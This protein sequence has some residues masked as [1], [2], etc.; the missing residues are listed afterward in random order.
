MRATSSETSSER[1]S[2]SR[3]DL[4]LA[5]WLGLAVGLIA[6]AFAGTSTGETEVGDRDLLF[7][8]SFAVQSLIGYAFLTA[9]TLAIAKLFPSVWSALGFRSF[10]LRWLWI[11]LGLT[12]AALIVSAALEPLVHAGE[13]QGLAP[14]EWDG[15][16]AGAFVVNAVV[17]ALLAPFAEELF[18]R[19]LGV[20]VLGFLG[21][22]G[23]VGG[24]ALAFALVHGLLSALPALG[25][26]GAVLA[27]VRYRTQSIWPGFIAHA[28][29]NGI[30][31]LAAV[32]FAL[33]E[34]GAPRLI[35]FL[36]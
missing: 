18:Y 33:D 14:T 4:A 30:G 7:E 34:S 26:F 24:T 12:V 2:W 10:R 35:G 13:E 32:Y 8:Y 25:F 15:D 5:L 22:T 11:T 6:L 16:R 28:L 27:Y 23:A 31:I 17:V 29:Y 19:G 9:L 36:L 21:A 20:R 1:S 3:S